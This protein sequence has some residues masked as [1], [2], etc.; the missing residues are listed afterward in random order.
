MART[1]A[2]TWIV[3]GVNEKCYLKI[4]GLS[5]ELTG[6]DTVR[7]TMSM[8]GMDVFV[9]GGVDRPDVTI[10]ADQPLE[11]VDCR[12]LSRFEVANGAQWCRFGVD[13]SGCCRYRFD[14]GNEVVYDWRRPNQVSMS[15]FNDSPILRFALWLAFGMATLPM[16]ITLV[17]SSTVVWKGRAVMCLGESGT[18]KSTH[19]RL[20]L[21]NIEGSWL[22][23]DDSP[24]VRIV[25]GQAMVYGSPWSGKTPC[26]INQGF[27]IAALVR[28]R[29]APRN[30]IVRLRTLEAFAALQPSCPPELMRAQRTQDLL[31]DFV[32][33]V[34]S[35]V[36][37][38]RL[39]CLPDA[40]AARLCFDTV[41]TR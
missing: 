9:A 19:T 27:P 7:H 18:G 2:R 20:W 14:D 26:Y 15:A 23:N 6:G 16:G 13:A 41:M 21:E 39:D 34:I 30:E 37:V 8:P 1:D 11:Q 5:V 29:Q 24:V 28:L 38:L 12:W 32:G 36:P 25:D 3:G 22:L 40:A 17:H 31:I 10:V 4:A 35:K 33:S